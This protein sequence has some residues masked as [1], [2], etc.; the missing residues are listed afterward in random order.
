M[1]KVKSLLFLKKRDSTD[2]QK[3]KTSQANSR[4][5]KKTNESLEMSSISRKIEIRSPGNPDLTLTRTDRTK[6]LLL[7]ILIPLAVFC[8]LNLP[9]SIWSLAADKLL[10][11]S[12]LGHMKNLVITDTVIVLKMTNFAINFF[13]YCATGSRFWEAFR[14]LRDDF[15][16][17]RNS[18][19]RQKN[20]H[21]V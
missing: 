12:D 10:N 14:N 3:T 19:Y 18:F 6:A 2:T 11:S 20:Q 13:F 8:F 1:D 9:H 15:A 4:H 7:R 17:F 5:S 21:Q 16:K